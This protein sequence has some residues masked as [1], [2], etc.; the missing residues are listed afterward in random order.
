MFFG[1]YFGS[2]YYGP[3]YWGTGGSTP[4]VENNYTIVTAVRYL[5][6]RPTGIMRETTNIFMKTS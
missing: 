3:S 6:D 2:N 1:R 4:P 5:P